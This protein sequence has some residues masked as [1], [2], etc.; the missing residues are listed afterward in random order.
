MYGEGTEAVHGCGTTFMGQF[1]YFGG[2]FHT[3]G[4]R[5]VRFYLPNSDKIKVIKASKIEGCKLVRQHDLPFHFASGVCN[6]FLQPIER[7]LLCFD[8]NHGSTCSA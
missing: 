2:Y 5:Q 1:W 8:D 7:V 6:S 4:D 3:I